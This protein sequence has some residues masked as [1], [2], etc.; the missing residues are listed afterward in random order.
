[1]TNPAGC[2][3]PSLISIVLPAFNEEA[4]IRPV[5]EALCLVLRGA[6][7]CEIIFVDDGS[8][9]GTA[10]AVR[11]LRQ[12]G[13]P[14]RLLRFGRNFGHQAALFAG[15][16]NARGQAVITMDCD[17]QHPPDRLP[18]MIQEWRQ[19]AKVVQMVRAD[20]VGASFFKQ[21]SSKCFYAFVNLLSETPVLTS[22]ADFQLL[23]RQVVDAV[24][25]FRDRAPFLRGLIGWLGFPSRQIPY[26][27]AQRHAGVSGYSLRKMVR[28]SIQAITGL[29]TKPLRLSFYLGLA[30]ATLSILYGCYALTERFAGLTVPG[31]TSM[32]AVVTFLGAV[33]LISVGI[34]GEYIGRIY[35]Q[36]RG[37][38]RCVIVELDE[39]IP[40]GVEPRHKEAARS[41]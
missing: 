11:R 12:E 38:P 37:V 21:V 28:L 20:T 34:L 29:S 5:Y 7:A 1:V 31:W 6:E 17:L 3:G 19:G 22:A 4:N 40:E 2:T 14:V 9:D 39:A 25:Q 35:E 32:V 10:A 30:V 27:A 24:L 16:E 23:D 8:S 15:L 36:S 33:Q 41:L 26:V 13:A 18:A